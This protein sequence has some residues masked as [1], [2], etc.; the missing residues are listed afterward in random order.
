VREALASH[1][2]PGATVAAAKAN[3]PGRHVALVLDPDGQPQAVAKV[4]T[5]DSGRQALKHEAAALSVL[6]PRLPAPLFAP[7][8]LARTDGL[9]LLEAIPWRARFRPW[10]LPE[11]VAWALGAFFRAASGDRRDDRGVG[12]AHGDCAPWNLLRSRSGWALVDWE[13]ARDDG[14]PFFDVFH[15]VT[16]SHIL[17]KRRPAR[18]LLA[19]LTTRAGRIG[20]AIDAYADGAGLVAEDSIRFL[21]IYLETSQGGLDPKSRSGRAGLQVRRELLQALRAGNE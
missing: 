11:D 10:D 16:Q 8:I 14:P 3:H 1:L 6:G 2:P 19:D 12:A 7:Q 21:P 15:Y 5:D 4:A 18:V 17:L 9:L 20:A 13:E